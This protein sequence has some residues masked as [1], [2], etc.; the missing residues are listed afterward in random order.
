M[1]LSQ[2]ARRSLIVA[3]VVATVLI[4]GAWLQSSG[5][6]F[7][8]WVLPALLA[9]GVVVGAGCNASLVYFAKRRAS[10]NRYCMNCGYDRTGLATTTLCP[11]CGR[12]H[13]GR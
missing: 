12:G 5:G 13:L 2:V 7:F 9:A 4:L 6:L 3:A 10:R 1:S 8:L 11:E